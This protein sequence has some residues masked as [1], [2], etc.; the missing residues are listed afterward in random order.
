MLLPV[1]ATVTSTSGALPLLP[2]GGEV[3]E[4]L[5]RTG[6]S[7]YRE[8]DHRGEPHRRRRRRRGG[9]VRRSSEYGQRWWARQD[10]NLGPIGYEPT[11][12]GR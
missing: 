3:A 5:A 2:H 4:I 12:L 8:N 11:A 9:S 1:G 7:A 10:S 6:L